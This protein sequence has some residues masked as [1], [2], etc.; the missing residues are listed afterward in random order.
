MP[1]EN[2]K[3]QYSYDLLAAARAKISIPFL[4]TNTHYPDPQT[5]QIGKTE[6]MF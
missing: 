5:P 1:Y 2:D 4:F 3:Y 6:Q